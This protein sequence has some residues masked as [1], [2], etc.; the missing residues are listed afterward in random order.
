MSIEYNTLSSTYSITI[1]LRSH[2]N[3]NIFHCTAAERTK[4]LFPL[5]VRYIGCKRAV[6]GAHIMMDVLLANGCTKIELHL[7]WKT[8]EKHTHTTNPVKIQTH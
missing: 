1:P 2:R 5:F 6:H 8:K 4:T 7:A 3:L